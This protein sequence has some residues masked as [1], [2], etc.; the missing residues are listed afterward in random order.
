MFC[1]HC[2]H[3]IKEGAAFCNKCGERLA[4]PAAGQPA[5]D[6]PGAAGPRPA[7]KKSR[8][9]LATAVA[10]AL[11]ACVVLATLLAPLLS[12]KPWCVDTWHLAGISTHGIENLKFCKE[13]DD[14]EE[15]DGGLVLDEDGSGELRIGT[16][17]Y[18]LTWEEG[19]SGGPGSHTATVSLEHEMG[20]LKYTLICN[21]P[22]DKRAP[23]TFICNNNQDL[24]LVLCR[25]RETAGH[26][27]WSQ[28]DL[29]TLSGL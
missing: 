10:A 4:A 6:S 27:S 26:T 1:T 11:V 13:F 23:A 19:E 28:S 15:D 22:G 17:T 5:P 20:S 8:G 18:P 21:D 14:S 2:G 12:P 3:E 9:K 7:P 16:T 29:P 24:V 25:D